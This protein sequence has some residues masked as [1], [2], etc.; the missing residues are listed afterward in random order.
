MQGFG[1]ILM[2]KKDG[3]IEKELS[4]VKIEKNGELLRNMFVTEDGGELTAR[5]FVTVWGKLADWEFEAV[6]DF[7]DMEVFDGLGLAVSEA[8]GDVNPVWEIAFPYIDDPDRLSA[9]AEGILNLHKREISGVLEAIKD[10]EGD[11]VDVQEM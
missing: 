2:L 4:T 11:Y 9:K 7:Y 5:M 8:P 6:Y 1:V 10:A 3:V